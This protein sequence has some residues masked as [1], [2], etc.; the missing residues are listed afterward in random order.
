[1][2]KLKDIKEISVIGNITDKNSGYNL[3]TK[4]NTQVPL[5]AQ[6]WDSL[7]IRNE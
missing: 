1:M 6:G 5:I 3:I 2:K 4:I 7:L